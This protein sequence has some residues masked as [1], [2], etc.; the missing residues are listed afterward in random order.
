VLI[1][2]D[3]LSSLDADTSQQVFAALCDLMRGKT[4]IVVTYHVQLL[5]AADHILL[6]D[7]GRIADQGSHEHLLLGNAFYQESARSQQNRR[8][9]GA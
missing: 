9:A 8:G 5:A 7:Q 3:G 1:V 4:L 2:D 6:M